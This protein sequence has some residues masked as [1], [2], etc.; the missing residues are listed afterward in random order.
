M[1]KNCGLW[2]LERCPNIGL[3]LFEQGSLFSP[4]GH[5]ADDDARPYLSIPPVPYSSEYISSAYI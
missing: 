3:E 2:P 5:G 1:S 4:A